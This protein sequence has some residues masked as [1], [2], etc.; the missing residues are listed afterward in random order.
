MASLRFGGGGFGWLDP[1]RRRMSFFS[2][3]VEDKA[4]I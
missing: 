1:K 4:E 3:F 2:K